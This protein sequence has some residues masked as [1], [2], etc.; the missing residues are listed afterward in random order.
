MSF[1]LFSAYWKVYFSPWAMGS[2]KS[3]STDNN[4]SNKPNPKSLAQTVSEKLLVELRVP[5]NE[6][7]HL[8]SHFS[9]YWKVYFFNLSHGFLKRITIVVNPKPGLHL[10]ANMNDSCG[11]EARQEVFVRCSAFADSANRTYI[12]IL[13]TDF[14]W[15]SDS[16]WTVFSCLLNAEHSPH[17]WILFASPR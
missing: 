17:S 3:S 1:S 10:N 15:S 11:S 8:F 13:N 12:K 4:E 5:K 14:L 7:F 16:P 9:L 2:V 6:L